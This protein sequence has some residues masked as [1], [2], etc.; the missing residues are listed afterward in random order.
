M[1]PN[2][3]ENF[4]FNLGDETDALQESIRVFCDKEISPLAESI[5]K[6]NDFPSHLWKKLGDMGLL[7]ITVEENFG[8]S[9]LGYL[10]HIIA[11]QEISRASASVGLSYGAHSNLCV[12]QIRLNG[13]KKQ[14]EKFLPKLISGDHVGA[15]AM[16]EA[17]SGSDVV[18]MKLKASKSGDKFILNGSKMW[19]TNA[20]NAN[21]FVVYAKTESK[22]DEKNNN[23]TAFIIE[24]NSKGFS[25]SPKLD[26]LGMRGSNTAELVFNDCEV[27]LENILGQT[28]QGT[29]V[30][31][32]GLDYERAV[33][34]G[35][36][37]GIMSS[38]WDIIIPYISERKQFGRPVGTFQLM[39]G[40]IADMYTTMNA[41][42]SY[43]Y[44]VAKAC[45][46]GKITRED[47]AGVL[48]YSS[49]KAVWMA[50]EAIQCLGGNGYINDYPTGRL[51]RDAKLYDIGAGTNEIR[52][53]L[54]G[55][56]VFKKYN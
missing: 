48:L 17:S 12:N 43:S 35:G 25:V 33:L 49:E 31:M 40:K 55:R 28:N 8:G 4:N 51:L 46:S 2:L 21:I 27:P 15:L 14:K 29:K 5:D 47:A 26:K 22:N 18:S 9:G 38:C 44:M 34:S 1:I 11:M 20:P 56:E 24:R 16:S 19:I 54:I 53:M 37:L 13:T 50:L 52:R 30:L 45:D 42:K 7:G 10:E 32:S 3:P 41:C 23:I 39:Q 36:P 6:N